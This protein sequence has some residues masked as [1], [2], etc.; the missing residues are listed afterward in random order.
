VLE[1]GDIYFFYRPKIEE[2]AAEGVADVQRLFMILSP[3]DRK[4][5]RLLVIGQKR[6]PAVSNQGA[7]TWGFVD[8]VSRTAQA[9]QE[10]LAPATYHTKTRG[11]RTQPAARP[12][13]EGVYAIVRHASHTHLVYALELPD[14]PGEVQEELQLT[15]EGSYIISVKN[16]EQP[17]P[18]GA[19]LGEERQVSFPR[20]LQGRFRSRRFIPVDPA[21]FLNYEG[22]EVL[23]IGASDDVTEELDVQLQPQEET[24]ATAEIFTDLGLQ[25]SRHPM[26]PLFEG[27]WE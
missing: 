10:D 14:E 2:A 5:Y 24:S 9:L 12:A 3:Q 26:K 23:L 13:G 22:V 1:R 25:K 8:K 16:P 19:G 18:P 27:V 4:R 21:S 6:L 15:A 17:S 7:R 20:T 11:E